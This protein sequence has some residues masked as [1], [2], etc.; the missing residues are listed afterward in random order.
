MDDTD[1]PV[2]QLEAFI[3]TRFGSAGSTFSPPVR[4]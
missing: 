4:R 1:D 3:R 2:R